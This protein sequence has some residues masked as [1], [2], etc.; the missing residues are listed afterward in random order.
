MIKRLIKAYVLNNEKLANEIYKAIKER[1]QKARI[2]I[3]KKLD[4]EKF[5]RYIINE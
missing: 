3:L 4:E 2:E 5:R 1:K